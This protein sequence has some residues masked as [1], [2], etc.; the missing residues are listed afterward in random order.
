MM[1]LHGVLY[2]RKA[3][4]GAAGLF[5]MA[6]ID[7]IEAL[8]HLILM[9]RCNADTGIADADLN[10]ALLLCNSNLNF[11]TEIVVRGCLQPLRQCR[12]VQQTR[13]QCE[14]DRWAETR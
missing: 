8:K 6:L 1:I 7:T 14:S 10:S 4:A 13:R 11:S 9:F 3:K 2:D 12:Q 5:G